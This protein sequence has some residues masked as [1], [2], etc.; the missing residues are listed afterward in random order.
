MGIGARSYTKKSPERVRG[1]SAMTRMET[2]TRTSVGWNLGRNKSRR[3]WYVDR[4]KEK[5]GRTGFDTST[6]NKLVPK[7]NWWSKLGEIWCRQM[8]Y[9][10]LPLLRK[11][12]EGG[13]REQSM[14]TLPPETR[15]IFDLDIFTFDIKMF[16][17]TLIYLCLN[18]IHRTRAV[19]TIVPFKKVFVFSIIYFIL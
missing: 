2:K 15:A 3:C 19:Y 11:R 4:R 18:Y 5:L 13:R 10:N 14:S 12:R 16:L 6:T 1:T 17:F 9:E 7:L 8:K